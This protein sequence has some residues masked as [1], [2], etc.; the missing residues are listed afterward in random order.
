VE[1]H[2]PGALTV[3]EMSNDRQDSPDSEQPTVRDDHFCHSMRDPSMP[4]RSCRHYSVRASSPSST[5]PLSTRRAFL[6]FLREHLSFLGNVPIP[7]FCSNQRQT[8]CS[9]AVII[10]FIDACTILHRACQL[11]YV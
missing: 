11:N 5:T 4:R 8:H 7:T 10:C 3:R 1:D 2:S 6:S 9:L